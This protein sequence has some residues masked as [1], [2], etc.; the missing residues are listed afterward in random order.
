MEKIS[1]DNDPSDRRL[2][3]ESQCLRIRAACDTIKQILEHHGPLDELKSLHRMCASVGE[4]QARAESEGRP[5]IGIIEL[6]ALAL[7]FR[8]FSVEQDREERAKFLTTLIM[9]IVTLHVFAPKHE[10]D[11]EGPLREPFCR[12]LRVLAMRSAPNRIRE[13]C[14]DNHRIIVGR[15]RDEFSITKIWNELPPSVHMQMQARAQELAWERLS[16]SNCCLISKACGAMFIKHALE[17]WRDIPARI[18]RVF[19]NLCCYIQTNDIREP[20][21]ISP[22]TMLQ[23]IDPQSAD[24][25]TSDLAPISQYTR[26]EVLSWCSS[27]GCV[28]GFVCHEHWRRTENHIC[29]AFARHFIEC[30]VMV[31]IERCRVHSLRICD[32]CGVNVS[33]GPAHWCTCKLR[34]YCGRECQ[35]LD[36]KHHKHLCQSE[37]LGIFE[38]LQSPEAERH[39]MQIVG[40][41]SHE[42]LDDDERYALYVVA[43]PGLRWKKSGEGG[44]REASFDK[45]RMRMRRPEG[46]SS[47]AV[48]DDIPFLG[49]VLQF[50]AGWL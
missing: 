30:L 42:V 20:C 14:R 37:R 9:E 32:V 15:T 29:L 31:C 41:P 7:M 48:L 5:E 49:Q 38:T 11:F 43:H 24:A 16:Q 40:I 45:I 50:P 12:L 18:V 22:E 46:A 39:L 23:L 8:E 44:G 1:I 36:W 4:F 28:A 26:D 47:P 33:E 6:E 27:E 19:S 10:N 13:S 17:H 34:I 25:A 3:S 35:K 21:E 2:L